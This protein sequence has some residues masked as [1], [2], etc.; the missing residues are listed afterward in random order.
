MSLSRVVRVLACIGLF[1][2]PIVASAIWNS[3]EIL[4]NAERYR[5]AVLVVTG[6]N[7]IGGTTNSDGDVS[8]EHCFIEGTIDGVAEEL[9][10]DRAS[11]ADA[12]VGHEIPVYYAPSLDAFGVNYQPLRV[13]WDLG[14]TPAEQARSDR[15]GYTRLSLMLVTSVFLLELLYGFSLRPFWRPTPPHIELIP[16]EGGVPAVGIGLAAVGLTLVL[17]QIQI[18]FA[19]GGLIFGLILMAIGLPLMARRVTEVDRDEREIRQRSTVWPIDGRVRRWPLAPE[20][21]VRITAGQW[22]GPAEVYLTVPHSTHEGKTEA[23]Q[24]LRDPDVERAAELASRLTFL[25]GCRL[26]E[27]WPQHPES[28]AFWNAEAYRTQLGE[29][30]RSFLNGAALRAGGLLLLVL[31][32]G[33][34]GSVP[35]IREPVLLKLVSPVFVMPTPIRAFAVR[36][37]GAHDT[38]EALLAVLQLANTTDPSWGP[39]LVGDALSALEQIAGQP[40]EG[41]APIARVAQ[42]NLFA[43]ERLGKTVDANGGVLDWFHVTPRFV[44]SIESVASSDLH[45]AWSAWDFLGVGDFHSAYQFAAAVGPALADERPIHFAIKRGDFHTGPTPGGL[46]FEGQPEPIAEHSDALVDTVG[47]ALALKMWNYDDVPGDEFPADFD[48]WWKDFAK[49]RL[50]PPLPER[51]SRKK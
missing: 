49:S 31:G 37:L 20:P 44:S 22:D 41:D 15:A 48:A 35:T 36:Q 13:L 10:A 7:C 23:M 28:G 11:I 9:P 21:E 26:D 27:R 47:G 43:A 30:R 34:A 19:L 18:A 12:P 5:A 42:A 29:A 4:E 33:M 2:G 8:P 3:N 24:L 46:A 39:D 25:L 32:L 16:T 38:D 17:W 6:S 51:A 45:E 1:F 50:L 14:E 40:F